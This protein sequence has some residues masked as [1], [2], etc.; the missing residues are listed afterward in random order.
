MACP[1]F[2]SLTLPILQIAGNGQDHPLESV[3]RR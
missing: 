3:E 1:D 2:Q